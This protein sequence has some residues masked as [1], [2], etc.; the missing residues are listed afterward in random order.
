MIDRAQLSRED[1]TLTLN[2]VLLSD[3]HVYTCVY[4]G[5]YKGKVNL[6]VLGK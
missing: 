5:G 6:K 2:S 3:E 1:G 4:P